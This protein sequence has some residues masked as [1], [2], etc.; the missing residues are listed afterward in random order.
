MLL[1]IVKKNRIIRNKF[2]NGDHK[3]N[4]L[5]KYISKYKI[6]FTQEDFVKRVEKYLLTGDIKT[7]KFLNSFIHDQEYKQYFKILSYFSK[8]YRSSI[9]SLSKLPEKYAK[10]EVLFYYIAKYYNYK[11]Q[12]NEI[13]KYLLSLPDNLKNP[14]RFYDLRIRNARFHIG[15]GNYELAYKIL[16]NHQLNPGG[17]Q[18]A[19][20][21]WLAGWLALRFI[22]KP[23]NAV[24]HF[25][26]IY[27][28]VSYPISLSRGSYWL[29]RSYKELG[30]NFQAD[31]WFKIA[32][33]YSTTYYGQMALMEYSQN[34]TIAI[35]KLKTYNNSEIRLNI[36]RNKAVKMSLYFNYIGYSKT[37]YKFA[38]YA[39]DQDPTNNNIHPFLAIYKKTND[40]RFITKIS[41]YTS[42]QNILTSANYP[43]INS[44][45]ANIK[46][47][48]LIFSIIKQE[49]GFDEKAVS[50]AGA[51]GFMQLMPKTAKEVSKKL[52]LKYS[53]NKL[54]NNP[55]YNITLGSYYIDQLLKRFDNSYILAVASYNAGP[56]NVSK[57]I[58]NIDDLRE[59]SNMY[60]IIDWVEL[61][62]Y[63]ETRNYVQRILENMVIYLHILPT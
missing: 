61:I 56:H 45:D 20:S 37:A 43:I 52:K 29:A 17:Y 57:W 39:I 15:E 55:E 53:Y 47:K 19:E 46:D 58:K 40:Y 60:D 7:A 16:S 3:L 33:K 44:I 13:S 8:K 30:K 28:N 26:N 38:K 5:K 2:I 59:Y 36:N 12:D 21:E 49:S 62:P 63:S 24:K 4:D 23:E 50:R 51:I 25:Q 27:Q 41:R 1:L 14:V 42:K 11:G 10:D 18:Y 31:K 48:A 34:L 22:N 35:P 54:K 32:S 9:S 6:I